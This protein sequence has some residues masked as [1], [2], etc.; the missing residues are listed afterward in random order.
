MKGN[1]MSSTTKALKGKR[2]L[3]C[4]MAIG[5]TRLVVSNSSPVYVS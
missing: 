3:S 5:N 4:L 2:I 1:L